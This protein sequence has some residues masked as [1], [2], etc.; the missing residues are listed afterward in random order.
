MFLSC[1]VRSCLNAKKLL[2]QNRRDTEVYMTATGFE[3]TTT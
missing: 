1:H 3:P 2:A